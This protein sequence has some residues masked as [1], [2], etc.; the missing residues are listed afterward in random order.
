MTC[1]R[2]PKYAG[3]AGREMT[4]CAAHAS[5]GT[6]SQIALDQRYCLASGRPSHPRK[7]HIRAPRG[8][9]TKMGLREIR[10]MSPQQMP[11]GQSRTSGG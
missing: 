9:D 6:S 7:A 2:T 8:L 11:I 1:Q 10:A 3:R 4:A 5:E